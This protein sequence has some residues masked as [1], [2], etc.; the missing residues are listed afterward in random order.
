MMKQSTTRKVKGSALS[1]PSTPRSPI[2]QGLLDTLPIGVVQ[3]D[4][5]LQILSVNGEAARLLGYSSDF[6][7]AKPIQDIWRQQPG[8]VGHTL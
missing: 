5:G 1:P 8:T 3:L 7:T 6:C 4:R 2:D